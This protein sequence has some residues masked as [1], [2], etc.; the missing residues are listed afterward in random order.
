VLENCRNP[1]VQYLNNVLEQDRRTIKRRV[2]QTS[3]KADHLCEHC[4]R[5]QDAYPFFPNHV[6]HNLSFGELDRTLVPTTTAGL[7]CLP[8]KSRSKSA[9]VLS[10]LGDSITRRRCAN[11]RGNLAFHA[12][13]SPTVQII[14]TPLIFGAETVLACNFIQASPRICTAG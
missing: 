13:G 11:L 6:E 7:I 14:T 9:A 2:R 4:R 12:L 10:A 1:R 8:P 3:V 5:P